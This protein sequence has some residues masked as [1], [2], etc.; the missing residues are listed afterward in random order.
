MLDKHLKLDEKPQQEEAMKATQDRLQAL[1]E[2]FAG[3]AKK[4]KKIEVIDV[5]PK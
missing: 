1:A 3:F 2:T 5:E 4:V